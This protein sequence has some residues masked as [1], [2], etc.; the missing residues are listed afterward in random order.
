MRHAWLLCALVIGCGPSSFDDFHAQLAKISCDRDVKCG[1]VAAA[2]RALCAPP[3]EILAYATGAQIPDTVDGELQAH[4][5]RFVSSGA[6]SCL[7]AVRAA[8][9]RYG[10]APGGEIALACHHVIAPGVGTGAACQGPGECIGGI[11]IE[12]DPTQPGA[13]VPYPVPGARC[14]PAALPLTQVVSCDP[15]VEYCGMSGPADLG[16]GDFV[17]LR[18]KLR[19]E[20]C[21]ADVE[22]G[23]GQICTGGK[24]DLPPTL[25]LGAACDRQAPLCR[26][27]QYCDATSVCAKL[28]K[29]GAPCDDPTS[30]QDGLAC[31]G[32]APGASGVCTPFFDAGQACTT[33]AMISGCAASDAC[34]SGVCAPVTR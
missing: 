28:Q 4:R 14:D 22:C 25:P 29:S 5:L 31:V 24:C 27:D 20:R 34:T 10:H 9:C 6:E 11:C 33:G 8:A 18:H 21:A 17:C 1:V 15:S 13:C 3:D 7:E 32:L 19:G 26:D 23:F 2:E 30:C 16:A 12:P